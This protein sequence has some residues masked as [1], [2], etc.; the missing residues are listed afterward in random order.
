MFNNTFYP[1]NFSQPVQNGF[2]VLPVAR[3]E[4]ALATLPDY[5]GTPLFFYNK[6]KNEVYIKKFDEMTAD[7]SFQKF[8][9]AQAEE[10][11]KEY[12]PSK[13]EA[14]IADIKAQ[15]EQILKPKT[16]K[17]EAKDDE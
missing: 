11:Q 14:E 4:E 17:K 2:R 3:E 1:Y 13:I 10:K 5:Q 9:L 16:I 12:D 7:V 15:L 6:S 8:V